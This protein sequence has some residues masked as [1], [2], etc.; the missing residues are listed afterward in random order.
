[1]DGFDVVGRQARQEQDHCSCESPCTHSLDEASFE[2][3]GSISKSLSVD[4]NQGRNK[5]WEVELHAD[6]VL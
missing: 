4:H 1:M 6:Q 3:G 2:S 5:R